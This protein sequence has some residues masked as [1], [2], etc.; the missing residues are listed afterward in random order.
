MT[1]PINN[2]QDILDAMEQNP[3]LRDAVRRYILTDEL[4][5]VPVR[6]ERIEGDISILKEGQARI[7]VDVEALKE[8]QARI[9]VDVEALKEG[10]ARI[11]V[12]VEALKEGQARIEV[13]VE[14][15][16][17]GQARLE[18]RV[19]RIGGN[20]SR[21]TGTDYES[22]VATYIHRILRRSLGINATVFSAQRDKSRLTRVLDEA[23]SQG[24][25]DPA[26]TD[27]LDRADLILTA[28][29]PTDYLLAEV[30]ITVQQ[31][32]IERAVERATLLAKATGRTV[33]PFAIGEREEPNLQRGNV[34]VVLIPDHQTY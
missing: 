11:E 19:D 1:T 4:L 31:D 28:D 21:L 6:I 17:E 30:S 33:T 29:G 12:D 15:L 2:F 27:E 10:Q 7:E 24:L 16:K 5:Q 22:H 14:A 8:G 18:Q 32:D 23:E 20:V 9:E 25:I 3:A 34:Q 13:D 26:D